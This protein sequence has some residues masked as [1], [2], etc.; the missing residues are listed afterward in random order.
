MNLPASSEQIVTAGF[1]LFFLGHLFGY[2][3]IY[4]L[5]VHLVEHTR[6]VGIGEQVGH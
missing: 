4:V 3:P 2:S 6:T 5:Q 1:I